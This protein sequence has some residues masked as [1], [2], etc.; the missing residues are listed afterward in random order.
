MNKYGIVG[1]PLSHSFSQKYF[2]QKFLDEGVTNAV[3][4]NYEIA[5]ISGI[6]TLIQDSELKGF[7]ITI[8]HKKNIIPFLT[9]S[10][11]A[12]KKMGACNCVNLRGGKLFGHNTDVIGFEKSF[13]PHLKSHHTKAL[14]LGTGG[15]AAAVQFVLEKLHIDYRFV[16][17][18][19]TE[20]NLSYNELTKDILDAYT[21]IINCTPLGTYPKVD[22][23]PEIP[24]QFISPA[25]YLF[26]LVYNPPLTKFLALGKEKG[27]IIQNGYEMLVIQAEE[28]W[29]IWNK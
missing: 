6:S 22:E 1:F 18:N 25:H 2:S 16:S 20:G 12:V 4:E 10:T 9:D 29:R 13:A 17:R 26:D 7:C 23:M 11:D 14:I 15:A 21:I 27:A 8:P 24:Y 19:K 5:D 3:F 28:N